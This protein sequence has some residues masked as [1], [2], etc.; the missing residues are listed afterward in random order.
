MIPTHQLPSNQMCLAK[1]WPGHPD[2]IWVGFAQSDPDS[3]C[4]L[5]VMA[6]TGRNQNVSRLDPACLLGTERSLT[7]KGDGCHIL[8]EKGHM[9]SYWWRKLPSTCFKW[10]QSRT[11]CLHVQWPFINSHTLF[12]GNTRGLKSFLGSCIRHALTDPHVL[13]SY[14]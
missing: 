2:R 10:R 3:G 11:V 4:M 7:A 5:A 9:S 6:I 12:P 13:E 14:G 1:P 8:H